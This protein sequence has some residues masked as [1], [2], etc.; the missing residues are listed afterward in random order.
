[1]T[2]G[3]YN[4]TARLVA[5][6]KRNGAHFL[7]NP[8]SF[9]NMIGPGRYAETDPKLRDMARRVVNWKEN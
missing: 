6:A 7:D 2:P 3:D 9:D 4:A 8:E 5:I 1:M